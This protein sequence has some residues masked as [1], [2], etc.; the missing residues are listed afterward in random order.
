MSAGVVNR[1]SV[2]VTMSRV[3]S[4]DVV[5]LTALDSRLRSTC[6]SRCWS[7]CSTRGTSGATVTENLRSFS[8]VSGRNVAST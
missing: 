7:E 1:S 3:T 4:P 2:A 8:A 5:N 6:W